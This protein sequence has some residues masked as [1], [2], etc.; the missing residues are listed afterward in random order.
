M[1]SSNHP[2]AGKAGIAP[3]LASGLS[4]RT[5]CA[6]T[7]TLPILFSALYASVAV[8][9]VGETNISAFRLVSLP[10]ADVQHG[11]E[12]YCWKIQQYQPAKTFRMESVP[13]LS[14]FY[15]TWTSCSLKFPGM[16]WAPRFDIEH[17]SETKVGNT[18]VIS[19]NAEVFATNS[20]FLAD[21]FRTNSKP[22]LTA[23]EVRTWVRPDIGSHNPQTNQA[24]RVLDTIVALAKRWNESQQHSS[25][26]FKQSALETNRP[27]GPTDS[28]R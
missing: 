15:L 9:A 24:L 16:T 14:T 17:T 20:S 22:S 21:A 13:K 27:S 1:N 5:C 7:A 23:L 19:F 18:S 28:R 26:A 10:L 8:A 11:A 4:C 2:A 6:M 12:E 25:D 3:R